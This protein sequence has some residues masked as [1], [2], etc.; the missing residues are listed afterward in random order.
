MSLQGPLRL[1]L[2]LLLLQLLPLLLLLLLIFLLLLLLYITT[3]I[4]SNSTTTTF[5]LN[6]TATTTATTTSTTTTTMPICVRK[7]VVAVVVCTFVNAMSATTTITTTAKKWQLSPLDGYLEIS[8]NGCVHEIPVCVGCG[9]VVWFSACSGHRRLDRSSSA[10]VSPALI[11]RISLPQPGPCSSI[12]DIY[13]SKSIF[14][15]IP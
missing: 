9:V 10:T 14:Q 13:S 4:T 12:I 3:T 11:Q 6:S 5:N 15:N 7:I 1:L 8:Q 2:P